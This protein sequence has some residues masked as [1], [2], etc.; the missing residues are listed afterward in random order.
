MMK[1]E[2]KGKATFEF[3]SEDYFL[4]KSDDTMLGEYSLNYRIDRS[5]KGKCD[6]IGMPVIYLTESEAELC[7]KSGFSEVY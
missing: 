3:S 2:I 1:M 7:R 4:C 6:D 5:E